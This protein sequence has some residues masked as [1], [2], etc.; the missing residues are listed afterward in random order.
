MLK[1]KINTLTVPCEESRIFSF[2]SST[3]KNIVVFAIG[4]RTRCLTKLIC[5]IDSGSSACC[6]LKSIAISLKF[7]LK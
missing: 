1:Q 2:A 3:I 5:C 4:F 7:S 6:L